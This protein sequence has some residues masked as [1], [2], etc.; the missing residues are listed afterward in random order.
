FFACNVYNSIE[1]E[2][3]LVAT[4]CDREKPKDLESK[5]GGPVNFTFG[6]RSSTMAENCSDSH[7]VTFDKPKPRF[8]SVE[9]LL[10]LCC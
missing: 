10:K 6:H 1:I 3:G 4:S 7:E 5:L 9:L 8:K 2:A